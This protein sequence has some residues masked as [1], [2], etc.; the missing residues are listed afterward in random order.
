MIGN[1]LAWGDSGYTILEEGELDRESVQ[2]RVTHYL[3]CMP[4]G[5]ALDDVFTL[6]EAKRE[7]ERLE[8]S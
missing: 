2:L 6:N 3:V 5:E 8:A 1:Q 7:I 4:S